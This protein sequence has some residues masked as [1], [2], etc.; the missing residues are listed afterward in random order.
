MP[1]LKFYLQPFLRYGGWPKIWKWSRDCF[2]T[3]WPNFAFFDNGPCNQSV[4]EIW[5]ENL[6]Q[7]LIY[8]YFTTSL[9]WLRNAYSRPF[10]GGFLGV[11]P[12][13]VVGYCGDP[14]RYVVGWKQALWGIDRPDR[15]RFATW[16]RAEKK[17]K[18]KKKKKR[19]LEMWQVT[20]FSR[21][22]TLR[23]PPPRQSCHVVWGTG[24]S[25]SCQ[26]SSKSI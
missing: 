13:N 24:R 18:K 23:Y 19:N 6:H 7:W 8:G 3:F 11:N 20:H 5:R 25:Q 10:W 26:V 21:P 4:C 9:I 14:K 12:L 16:T 15:S 22:P 1:N 2:T 17:T